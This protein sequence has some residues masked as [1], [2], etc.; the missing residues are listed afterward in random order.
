MLWLKSLKVNI[1]FYICYLNM[2]RNRT[3]HL[4][5][6]AWQSP[7][8]NVGLYA[9]VCLCEPCPTVKLTNVFFNSFRQ[10][11]CWDTE[12]SAMEALDTL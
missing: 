11:W 5:N 8:G 7:V 3:P 10:P 6:V 1:L 12:G 2:T 9:C 4:V